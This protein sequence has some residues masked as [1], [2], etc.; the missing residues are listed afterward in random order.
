MLGYGDATVSTY[1][2]MCWWMFGFFL[3]FI[4]CCTFIE[5][6]FQ[7]RDEV[8][9]EFFENLLEGVNTGSDD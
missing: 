9:N 5:M 2:L 1:P 7:Q 8:E 3:A 6:V 4:A